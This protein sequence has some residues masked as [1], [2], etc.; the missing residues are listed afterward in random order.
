[1]ILYRIGLGEIPMSDFGLSARREDPVNEDE[2]ADL[3]LHKL[4]Q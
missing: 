2:K 1:M 4:T 3:T